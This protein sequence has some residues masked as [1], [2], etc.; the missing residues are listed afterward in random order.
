MKSYGIGP[1][2]VPSPVALV[3]DRGAAQ[4]PLQIVPARRDVERRRLAVERH[5]ALR[6]QLRRTCRSARCRPTR[7]SARASQSCRCASTVRSLLSSSG[8]PTLPAMRDAGPDW[9]ARPARR[10]AART[11]ASAAT[12]RARTPAAST[13]PAMFQRSSGRVSSAVD[14]RALRLLQLCREFQPIE[15]AVGRAVERQLR[16][17]CSSAG[18]QSRSPPCRTAGRRADVRSPLASNCDR[19]PSTAKS[20]TRSVSCGD[21]HAAAHAVALRSPCR[22]MCT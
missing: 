15:I 14:R 8:M 5:R 4:R 3:H 1:R 16:R 11:A 20:R 17:R 7:S 19:A 12:D 18:V 22:S 21:R 2:S 9:P 13:W 6:V 10:C